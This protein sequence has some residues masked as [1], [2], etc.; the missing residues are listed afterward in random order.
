MP[1]ARPNSPELSDTFRDEL[2]VHPQSPRSLSLLAG[3][4]EYPIA[5]PNFME[6]S[7]IAHR[8]VDASSR[9]VF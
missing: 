1:D 9:A 6:P 4:P 7:S 2:F 8:R 5:S 3:R